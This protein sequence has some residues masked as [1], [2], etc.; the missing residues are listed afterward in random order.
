MRVDRE[1]SFKEFVRLAGWY[2]N[3]EPVVRRS[4]WRSTET[5][6][7]EVGISSASAQREAIT[8]D[9]ETIFAHDPFQCSNFEAGERLEWAARGAH[10]GVWDD[11]NELPTS[12]VLLLLLLRT[13]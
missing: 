8:I 2:V 11:G 5:V 12:I 10:L 1:L 13:R 9:R 4:D 3:G 7:I 6:L